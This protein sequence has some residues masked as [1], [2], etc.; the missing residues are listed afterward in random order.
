V[1]HGLCK[2]AIDFGGNTEDYVTLVSALVTV[3]LCGRRLFN[4]N[5]FA[6]S[7]ALAK[8]RD[9]L[10]A[11]PLVSVLFNRPIFL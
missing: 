10:S 4:S 5:N 11:T 2:T 3:R 7:A 9:L 6:T 1:A 8:V